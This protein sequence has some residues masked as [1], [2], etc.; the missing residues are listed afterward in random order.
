MTSKKTE[1]PHALNERTTVF[2]TSYIGRFTIVMAIT[3]ILSM[4]ISFW[5]LSAIKGQLEE[6]RSGGKDSHMLAVATQALAESASSQA[7]VLAEQA[8]LLAEQTKLDAEANV[9][10]RQLF[11]AQHRPWIEI[12]GGSIGGNIPIVRNKDATIILGVKF[13]MKNVGVIPAEHL[14]IYGFE[15]IAGL[16]A[17]PLDGG[18]T[19]FSEKACA[20][21][22]DEVDT[23]SMDTGMVVYPDTARK[24]EVF[25]YQNGI[26]NVGIPLESVFDPASPLIIFHVKYRSLLDEKLHCAARGFFL[27]HRNV[28]MKVKK[29]SNTKGKAMSMIEN[30]V[31]YLEEMPSFD[32]YA[33]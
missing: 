29:L 17:L 7:A 11:L 10:N 30:D 24:M 13:E 2:W 3:S 18:V 4:G 21:K 32:G 15:Y 28:A 25:N 33:D 1:S 19:N 23:G 27:R 12:L 22:D 26:E 8:K 9:Q 6:M 20:A 5:T 31:F 16:R 14:Q